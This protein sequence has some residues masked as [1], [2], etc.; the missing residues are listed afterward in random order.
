MISTFCLLHTKEGNPQNDETA[1]NS[2]CGL[3]S[4]RRGGTKAMTYIKNSHR[5]VHD[6]AEGRERHH[7]EDELNKSEDEEYDNSNNVLQASW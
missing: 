4:V 7:V 1:N 2:A 5:D 3:F 6:Q